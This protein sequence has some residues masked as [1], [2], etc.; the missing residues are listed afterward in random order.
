M[1]RST[2]G[3]CGRAP[4]A[5]QHPH[6]G[7]RWPSGSAD[8]VLL[9]HGL[10]MT[11]DLNW[12]GAFP[13]L[14]RRFR[15][16]ALDLPG[17]GRGIPSGPRFRLEECADDVA[18]LAKVLGID[19]F[20]AVGCS[21]GCLVAQ[22]LWRLHRPPVA[23]LVLTA[24]A[25]NF[26]GS[27]VERL[28]GVTW[29][30][31]AATAQLTPWPQATGAHVLGAALLGHIPN[32]AVLQWAVSEMQRTSLATAVSALQAVSE[33]TSH[34]W[35]G[36]VDVP[37]AVIVTTHD[38]VVPVTRQ[39]RLARA[40]PGAVLHELHHD[41][42]VCV[43]AP[44]RFGGGGT[45]AAAQQLPGSTAQPPAASLSADSQAH[46]SPLEPARARRGGRRPAASRPGRHRGAA[47]HVARRAPGSQPHR[48]QGLVSTDR[49]PAPWG[50][51]A[52]WDFVKITDIS[53]TFRS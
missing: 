16:V 33:F 23:G 20:I 26:R 15:V 43:N 6:Q 32:L 38:Q 46:V 25:R 39:L 24:T 11:A 36:A 12:F 44:A 49:H 37:T 30:A 29:P 35:V 28:V 1:V 7:V 4:G 2:A 10:T 22:L 52:T 31:I 48:P 34:E 50:Q 21:M 45:R 8:R 18:L 47:P 14:G 40:I 27:I 41:H 9:I 51:V 3:T 5:R 53:L 13:V 17:H 19:R 42:G